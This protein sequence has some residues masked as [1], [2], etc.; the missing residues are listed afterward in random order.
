MFSPFT[1]GCES[2]R[3]THNLG[4]MEGKQEESCFGAQNAM[5]P[6]NSTLPVFVRHESSSNACVERVGGKRREGGSGF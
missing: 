4:T 5:A 1:L 6:N 3:T 2:V